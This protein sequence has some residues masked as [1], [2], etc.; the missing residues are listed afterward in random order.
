M[1][2]ARSTFI[3]FASLILLLGFVSV[4]YATN[5]YFAHGYSVQNKALAGAGTA[6]PLD[7]LAAST[8]PAGMVWVGKRVDF[9]LSVFNPNREYTVTGNPSMV[10]GTFGLAPGTVKSDSKWFVIPSAGFNWMMNDDYSL[11]VSLEMAV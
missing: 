4:S 9:G 5:G 3:C 10:P 11:G 7:T 8:N 6:L 2:I 1:K